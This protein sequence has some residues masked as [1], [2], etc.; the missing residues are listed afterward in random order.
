MSER[1]HDP[2]WVDKAAEAHYEAWSL[3][4]AER[5]G[6]DDV[7]AHNLG[8]TIAVLDAVAADIAAAERERVA[9]AIEALP[10]PGLVGIKGWPAAHQ[11]SYL[12]AIEEAARVARLRGGE[13][14]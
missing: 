2:A 14:S 7:A 10:G 8:M 12:L 11:E 1:K 6:W 5:N 9:A 4:T 13:G 3:N